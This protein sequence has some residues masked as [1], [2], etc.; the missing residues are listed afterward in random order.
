MRLQSLGLVFVGVVIGVFVGAWLSSSVPH[1]AGSNVAV[2]AA[3]HGRAV[4]GDNGLPIH[5][6]D[7]NR[8]CYGAEYFDSGVNIGSGDSV[9][10]IVSNMTVNGGGSVSETDNPILSALSP[11]LTH[12]K[13]HRA[14]DVTGCP[15]AACF[16]EITIPEAKVNLQNGKL[17]KQTIYIPYEGDEVA[18]MK[19][20][21]LTDT[22]WPQNTALAAC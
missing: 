8:P 5:L 22:G 12:R 18:L 10:E 13:H 14:H 15:G 9:R 11:R 2:A 6:I 1:F 4:T 3:P 17:R 19:A 16:I 20:C 21:E 7:C